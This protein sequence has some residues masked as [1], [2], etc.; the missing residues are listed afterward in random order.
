MNKPHLKARIVFLKPEEGG[1]AKPHY[2]GVKPLLK[3]KD[4]FTSCIVWGTTPGQLFEPGEEHEVSLEL[5][6]WTE[7]KDAMFIGMPVQLNDGSRVV[8]RGVID[9]ILVP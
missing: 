7:Y 3:V 2:S 1:F 9:A 4:Q 5:P 6:S 8:G